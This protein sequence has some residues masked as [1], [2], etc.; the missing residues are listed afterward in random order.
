MKKKFA[1]SASAMTAV[2]AMVL[3]P[4]AAA[5]A[6]G[7]ATNYGCVGDGIRLRSVVQGTVYHYWGSTQSGTWFNSTAL[8]RNT[9]HP[10]VYA[11]HSVSATNTIQSASVLC[12]TNA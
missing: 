8:P 9:Y 3:I 1:I 2:L 4:A 10:P 11:T 7:W 6:N 5:S 12:Y